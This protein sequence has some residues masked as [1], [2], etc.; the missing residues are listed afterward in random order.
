MIKGVM[1]EVSAPNQNWTQK[2]QWETR[3]SDRSLFIAIF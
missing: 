2:V 1:S 3:L